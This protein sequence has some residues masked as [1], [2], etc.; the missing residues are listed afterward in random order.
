MRLSEVGE[1]SSM[2]ETV[3]TRTTDAGRRVIYTGRDLTRAL[4]EVTLGVIT[5]NTGTDLGASTQS[6][7]VVSPSWTLAGRVQNYRRPNT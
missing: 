1:M 7:Q 5:Y 2:F 3:V 4:V 6:Q